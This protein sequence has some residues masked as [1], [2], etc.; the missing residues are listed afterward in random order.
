MPHLRVITYSYESQLGGGLASCQ[1]LEMRARDFT[2]RPEELWESTNYQRPM[3]LVGHNL[4][5]LLIIQ[6]LIR[7][8]IFWRRSKALEKI[9]PL[10]IFFGSPHGGLEPKP[11]RN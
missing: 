8:G 5:Y 2:T 11:P 4:G 3:I 7:S 6:A 1:D 10:I 9:A